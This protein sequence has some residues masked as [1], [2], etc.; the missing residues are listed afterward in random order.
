MAMEKGAVEAFRVWA[1][2]YDETVSKELERY[3]RI[4][5]QEVVDRLL[6]LAQPKDGDLSL[7][8]QP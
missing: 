3:A 4:T 7:Q 5:D 2:T 8:L 6:E 1:V